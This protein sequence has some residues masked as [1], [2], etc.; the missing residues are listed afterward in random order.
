MVSGHEISRLQHGLQLI[1]AR[2]TRIINCRPCCNLYLL[3]RCIAVLRMYAPIVTDWVASSVGLSISHSREPWK[4]GWTDR[5][6]TV[7]VVDSGECKESCIRWGSRSSHEKGRFWKEEAAQCKVY[8][9]GHSAVSCAKNGWT[10]QDAV[11]VVD[12]DGPKEGCVTWD[13]YWRNLANTIEPSVCCGDAAFWSK[14][15]DHLLLLLLLESIMAQTNAHSG[16]DRRFRLL[17]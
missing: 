13:A 5:R 6:D 11:W 14:F 10:D 3:I 8:R 9:Y 4:D 2:Y 12:S 16:T 1:M 15:F 17:V 7:W